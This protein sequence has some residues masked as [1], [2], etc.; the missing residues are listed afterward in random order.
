MLVSTAELRDCRAVAQPSRYDVNREMLGQLGLASGRAGVA[1][2]PPV[3]RKR[4]FSNGLKEVVFEDQLQ[5]ARCFRFQRHGFLIRSSNAGGNSV[6]W[7]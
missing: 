5:L 6:F 7:E 4:P 1:C 2:E 3:E